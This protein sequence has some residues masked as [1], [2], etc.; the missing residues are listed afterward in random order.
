MNS[1][2]NLFSVVMSTSEPHGG[3]F[4]SS[5]PLSTTLTS[6]QQHIHLTKPVRP[7]FDINK[8]AIALFRVI[9]QDECG[10]STFITGDDTEHTA[11]CH[12]GPIRVYLKHWREIIGSV[13]RPVKQLV[14][15][16]WSTFCE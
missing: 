3:T 2:C 14:I 5:L 11:L 9:G 1:E 4:G 15:L 12:V 16:F 13:S 7:W 6:V 8:S 10:G